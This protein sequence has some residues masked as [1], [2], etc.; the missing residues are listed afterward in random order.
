METFLA[1]L[2]G[3]FLLF[4]LVAYQV[5]LRDIWTP[6]IALSLKFVGVT[7]NINGNFVLVFLLFLMGPFLVQHNLHAL[8]YNCFIGFVSVSVLCAALCHHAFWGKYPTHYGKEGEE[9]SI[10]YFTQQPSD[11][12]F[13]FPI[14]AL[15]FLSHFNILSV[16]A[17]LV[18]P[19]RERTRL[20]IRTAVLGCGFL[21]Y[22]FG[23]GGYVYAGIDTKGN[24]LLNV[25]SYSEDSAFLLGQIGMGITLLV[26]TPVMTIPCR[27]NLLEVAEI[28]MGKENE[29]ETT[30]IGEQTALLRQEPIQKD[31]LLQNPV[32][33]YG[34]TV[35]IVLVTYSIAVAVPGVAVVWSLCGSCMAFLVAFILP[36]AYFLK[37][38][39]REHLE[40]ANHCRTLFCILL[41]GISAVSAVACTLQ[42]A[43]QLLEG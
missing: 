20:V 33:H 27:E 18:Q 25:K 22:L 29:V 26:A 23:L 35:F 5:L 39:Q 24:I 32:W 10:L 30:L 3:I 41:L 8:R 17:N 28:C 16:Q 4:V 1:V 19:T 6:L 40:S 7:C 36:A 37:I 2:L 21:M 12:L 15:S 34:S 31:P 13:A 14:I 38:T 43:L 42:T 11:I 9:D